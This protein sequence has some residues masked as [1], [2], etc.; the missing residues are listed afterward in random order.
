MTASS[1]AQGGI[2][3][4]SEGGL[5]VMLDARTSHVVNQ[6]AQM[7]HPLYREEQHA[8]ATKG[9]EAPLLQAGVAGP[10]GVP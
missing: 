7:S 3:E 8:P 9:E 5:C 4:A 6:G 10:A 1:S 2:G